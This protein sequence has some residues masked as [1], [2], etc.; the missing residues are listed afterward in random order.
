MSLFTPAF[1]WLSNWPSATLLAG[2]V[3]CIAPASGASADTAQG[4]TE[5]S[6]ERNCFGCVGG[7]RLLLRSDGSAVLTQVGNARRGSSDQVSQAHVEPHEFTAMARLLT[8]HGFFQMQEIYDDPALQDGAW[9]TI[10]AK[11]AQAEKEVFAR[12]NFAPPEL[13]AVETAIDA[14]QKRLVFKP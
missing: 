1:R 14:L 11:R 10:R 9:M 4:I 12:E 13:R 2:L 7:Q 3:W 8:A 5:I 6:I